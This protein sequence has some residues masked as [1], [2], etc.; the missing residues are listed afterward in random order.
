MEISFVLESL[1]SIVL[2]GIIFKQYSTF[3]IFLDQLKMKSLKY[4]LPICEIILLIF[5]ENLFLAPS[6]T[7]FLILIYKGEFKRDTRYSLYFNISIKKFK[8]YPD[9][10]LHSI[11]I[12]PSLIILVHFINRII[13]KIISPIGISMGQNNGTILSSYN[14]LI[15]YGIGFGLICIIAPIVE[16][17]TFRVMIY[18][19]WLSQKFSKRIFAVIISSII[20]TSSHFNGNTILFTFITGIV[21]CFIYDKLG[22]ISSVIVHIIFNFYAFLG[23]MGIIIDK[24][25]FN[26]LAAICIIIIVGFNALE[27]N[28]IGIFRSRS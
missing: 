17:L 20:F 9:K 10:I 15:D 14:N 19:C 28:N 27:L 2:F 23:F 4:I 18:D 13:I 8:I 6:V 24:K 22:Y 12:T 16:E 7:L 1:I 5:F 11:L 3:W 21:L 25:I 26:T